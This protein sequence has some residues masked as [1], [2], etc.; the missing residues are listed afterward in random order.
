MN[1]LAD[2]NIAQQVVERLR[3][4]GHN[5]RYTIQGQGLADTIVLDTAYHEQALILTDNKDFGDLV[6]QQGFQTVG[7]V[8]VR[9]PGVSHV[10]KAEIVAGVFQQYNGSLMNAFTVITPSKVRV[11]NLRG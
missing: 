10:E 3:Q 9:L 7:V 5:V 6:I 2:E 11:R 1:I 4:D 8:L